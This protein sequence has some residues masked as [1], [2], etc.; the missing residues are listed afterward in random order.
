V[1]VFPGRFFLA[2]CSSFLGLR[3]MENIHLEINIRKWVVGYLHP[4]RVG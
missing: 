3:F 2:L 1:G 4:A